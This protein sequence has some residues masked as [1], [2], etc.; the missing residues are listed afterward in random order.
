MECWTANLININDMQF[1]GL[2]A[3]SYTPSRATHAD[4]LWSVRRVV[5][6]SATNSKIC[7]T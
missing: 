3:H 1:C 5:F 4:R 6:V 2:V 7:I